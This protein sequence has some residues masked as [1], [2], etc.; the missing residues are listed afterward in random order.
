MRLK[1]PIYGGFLRALCFQGG[2]CV[3]KGI[4]LGDMD[5][6]QEPGN[7]ESRKPGILTETHQ[8]VNAVCADDT[9][10]DCADYAEAESSVL[11]SIRHR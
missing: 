10:N 6:N 1:Q 11:E 7:Q 5:Q 8:H 3:D 4:I 2:I 9:D